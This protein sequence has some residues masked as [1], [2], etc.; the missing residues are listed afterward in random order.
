M[1]RPTVLVVTRRMM[2]KNR[3]V[4]FLGEIH[5]ELLMRLGILPVMVP[6]AEGTPAC[7]PQY[8][9]GMSGLLLVEG[10]DV[11][12]TRYEAQKSNFTYLE[13]ISPL[14]DEIE[15][16][17]LRHAMGRHLPVLGICRGSHL[18]NVVSGGTLYGDVQKEKASRLRHI[19][20]RRNH[21]DT[22]RH[23]VTVVDGSPLK[24]WYGQSKLQVNSYHHQGVRKLASRFHPMATA[25]DG[26]I[27]AFYDPAAN[28]LVG[29]QFHPERML[30]EYAGNW[31]V[32]KAF[33]KAVHQQNRLLATPQKREGE[34]ARALSPSRAKR[35][36]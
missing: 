17:L 21:Y 32:W 24:R 28:F 33:G 30:E 5:F 2:R 26:L 22:Y 35:K 8:M 23:A 6:M 9:Q 4:N 36:L 31:Q 15:I 19:D 27:E 25:D 29:L 16:R 11:E 18:L 12:P 7:L 13:E 10:D 34:S 1:N 20:L 14:K 3:P